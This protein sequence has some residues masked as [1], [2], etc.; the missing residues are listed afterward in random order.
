[1]DAG[2]T[3]ICQFSIS[4]RQNPKDKTRYYDDTSDEYQFKLLTVESLSPQSSP[5]TF[6]LSR[7]NVSTII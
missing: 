2:V 7:Y 5:S 4:G 6:A 3:V 1:L